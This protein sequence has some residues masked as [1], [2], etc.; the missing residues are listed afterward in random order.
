[1]EHKLEIVYKNINTLIP[2][3]NNTRTHSKEQIEQVKA[4]I[5]EFGMCTPVGIHNDTLV[6]GHARVQ[7]MKELGYKE[8]PTVDLSHLTEAQKKAYIIADNKIA[9]NAGWDEELLKLEI[10]SLQDMDFNIDLLGF[11]KEELADLDIGLEDLA[12]L[13]TDKAD[14][15]PELTENPVIKLGDIIELGEHRVLC[16][17]S[18]DKNTI[19]KLMN[20]V[21]ADICFTD[22]DY[23]MDN[24]HWI[25]CILE[26]ALKENNPFF[27]MASDKQQS[28]YV[29][30]IPNFR[31]FFAGIRSQ[32]VMISQ[33]VPM[34]KLTLVSYFGES[35]SKFFNNLKDQF[36]DVFEFTRKAS[37]NEETEG[38]RHYKN[39]EVPTHFLKHYSKQGQS[40]VDL[41]GGS[42]STLIAADMLAMNCFVC[43]LQPTYVQLIIERYCNYSSVFNIKINGVDVD[44]ESYKNKFTNM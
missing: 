28:R 18:T 34:N 38:H 33:Y 39:V 23:A 12:E 6:Y 32:P 31:K 20:G 41:F 5:K 4:S 9:L 27:I 10:E 43:E 30:K 2:Y 37:K 3:I 24:D 35:P 22:P 19:I 42:G 44:W 8:V 29:Q 21:K 11:N 16:G 25:N 36:T 14:E 13:D 1:M 26:I 15:V 17:D 40:V 7:S